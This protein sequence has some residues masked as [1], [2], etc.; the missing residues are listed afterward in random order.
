MHMYEYG[1]PE[2]VYSDLGTSIVATGNVIKD[3]LKDP[4]TTLY[5]K[6]HNLNPIKFEQYF[7]GNSELGH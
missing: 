5:L 1:V 7:K 6:H 4:D 2:T 3:F